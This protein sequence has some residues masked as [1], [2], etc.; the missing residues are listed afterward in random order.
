MLSSGNALFDAQDISTVDESTESKLV[1]FTGSLVDPSAWDNSGA[2][3]NVEI[4]NGINTFTLRVD[5]NTTLAGSDN[6]Q[7]NLLEVVGIGGQFDPESPFDE[8]YQ[9]IP[10]KLEDL[11]IILNTI[12]P[13]LGQQVKVYPNPATGF[14]VIETKTSVEQVT[15]FNSLGQPVRVLS[16]V[17]GNQMLN[18][19]QI[20]S[21]LYNVVFR[22]GQSI[23]TEVLMVK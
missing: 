17:S 8:G 22:N 13:E 12:D 3:F 4:T 20:P 9:L 10:R 5:N 11:Q 7:G 19:A 18:L 15:L 16:E 21:G 23:W 6:P 1:R 14:V 2:S